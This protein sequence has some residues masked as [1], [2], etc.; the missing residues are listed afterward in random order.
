MSKRRS[1]RLNPM[2]SR[3]LRRKLRAEAAARAI[4]T[5]VE[6]KEPVTDTNQPVQQELPQQ[7]GLE[8]DKIGHNAPLSVKQKPM[9]EKASK[10]SSESLLGDWYS[11]KCESGNE[12]VKVIDV[13]NDFKKYCA[14]QKCSSHGLKKKVF[15]PYMKTKHVI[16]EDNHRARFFTDFK[17]KTEL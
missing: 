12:K 15:L 6:A 14:S 13:W 2:D 1:N 11:V 4:R 7:V 5:A 3:S 8:N 17:W 10:A 9:P 16:F